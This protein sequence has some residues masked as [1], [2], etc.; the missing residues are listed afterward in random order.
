MVV[1][2]LPNATGLPNGKLADAEIHFADGELRGCK[3]LGFSVWQRRA[4]DGQ[5][6]TFPART[7]SV[8]G[9]RRSFALLRPI[10]DQAAQNAIRD[11]ILKAYAETQA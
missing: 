5:N 3:L 6:V 2:V 1:K 4:G 11:A 10:E 9:E 7:Y 8:N